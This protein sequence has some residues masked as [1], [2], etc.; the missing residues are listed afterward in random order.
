[1]SFNGNTDG[2]ASRPILGGQLDGTAWLEFV[3]GIDDDSLTG[4][5]ASDNLSVAFVLQ[6]NRHT[7]KLRMAIDNGQYVPLA[8]VAEQ[9]T[10]GDQKGLGEVVDRNASF[11]SVAIS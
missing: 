6:A 5:Q 1:M 2:G 11:H 8:L 3:A 9:R 7:P 4:L 10:I